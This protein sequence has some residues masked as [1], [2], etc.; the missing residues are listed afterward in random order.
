MTTQIEKRGMLQPH[1]VSDY[2]E[3]R[4]ASAD[5]ETYRGGTKIRV[6]L[7]KIQQKLAQDEAALDYLMPSLPQEDGY[8]QVHPAFAQEVEADFVDSYMNMNGLTTIT[9]TEYLLGLY[10]HDESVDQLALSLYANGTLN[11][12]LEGEK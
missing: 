11:R 4:A 8:Y 10:M 1:D 9:K 12:L 3:N 2:Y 7:K 5:P 6:A